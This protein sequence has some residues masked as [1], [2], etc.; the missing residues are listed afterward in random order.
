MAK[1]V[2]NKSVPENKEDFKL[3]KFSKVQILDSKRFKKR[4]DILNVVLDDKKTYTAKEVEVILENKM[5]GEV[6]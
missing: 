6:K 4:R 1:T 3:T 2:E 5:K